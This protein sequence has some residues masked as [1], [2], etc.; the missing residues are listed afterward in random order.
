MSTQ[1]IDI[2]KCYIVAFT[3]DAGS[4]HSIVFPMSKEHANQHAEKLKKTLIEIGLSAE[5]YG[6]FQTKPPA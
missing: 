6:H 2:T 1:P 5:K 4:V 3:D